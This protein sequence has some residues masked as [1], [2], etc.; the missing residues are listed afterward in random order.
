VVKE[1]RAAYLVV[2]GRTDVTLT[3][4]RPQLFRTAL[5]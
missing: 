4:R 3:L 2:G 5:G 1:E